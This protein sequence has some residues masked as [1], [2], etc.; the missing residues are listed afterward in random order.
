MSRGRSV[1][2]TSLAPSVAVI[3]KASVAD[4]PAGTST[5]S[6][7]E[8]VAK[9]DAVAAA[10]AKVQTVGAYQD[11]SMN[12]DVSVSRSAFRSLSSM[13]PPAKDTVAAP[14]VAPA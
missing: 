14:Q 9:A 1:D 13:R 3:R 2:R 5:S 11:V 12:R 7:P 10:E 6:V 4:Q 8:V